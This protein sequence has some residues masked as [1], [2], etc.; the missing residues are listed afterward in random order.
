[1]DKERENCFFKKTCQP[2][3]QSNRR[4][5]RNSTTVCQRAMDHNGKGEAEAKEDTGASSLV[6]QG[7]AVLRAEKESMKSAASGNS[8]GG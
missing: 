3:G 4:A 7:R 1:M 5:G 2:A 8:G 6:Q